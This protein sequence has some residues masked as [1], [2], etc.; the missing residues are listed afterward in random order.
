M[1]IIHKNEYKK[2]FIIENDKLE[3]VRPVGGG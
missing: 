3:I 2:I 1:K